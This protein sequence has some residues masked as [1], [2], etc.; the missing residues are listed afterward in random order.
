MAR[1]SI[2]S[3]TAAAVAGVVTLSGCGG[4]AVSEQDNA[5]KTTST[6]TV[7]VGFMAPKSGPYAIL[8]KYLGQGVDLYLDQH[9]KKIGGR[10]LN[11]VQ[12]DEGA[13]PKTALPEVRKLLQQDKVVALTGIINSGVGA[14]AAPA[15]TEAG[16]PLLT[17][18]ND[19]AGKYDHWWNAGWGNFGTTVAMADYLGEQAKQDGVYLIASDYT[20]GH[21]V[22]GQMAGALQERGVKVVGQTFSPYGTTKDYQ[23][24]LAKIK[25]S[26]AK[27]VFAFFAGQ[28]A[29]QF[30]QQ[31]KQFGLDKSAQLY[32]NF[33]LTEGVL[34]AERDA[35]E[36]IVTVSNYST[37]LDNPANKAF[38]D[39]FTKKFNEPPTVYAEASYSAM[40]ALDKTIGGMKGAVT[41][42]ALQSALASMG[43]VDSP[44]GTWTFDQNRG[45]VENFYILQVKKAA[46]G[47]EQPVIKD[48]GKYGTKGNK[49]Q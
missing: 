16:V 10:T 29:I 11:L 7:N 45:P 44:R 4:S 34:G 13:D 17:T 40:L 39:A 43:D 2:I 19:Y 8:G 1:K 9:G 22:I 20:G 28:E 3:A 49:V 35:A 6:S 5:A 30:V 42:P 33:A 14:A 38:V 36:G 41:G 48:S 31:Y 12:A 23:P 25:A 47:F 26:G 15:L 24:Y 46:N 21:G 32:S 27:H 37:T 18:A